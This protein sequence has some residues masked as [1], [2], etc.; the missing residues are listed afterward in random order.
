MP[1]PKTAHV[2]KSPPAFLRNALHPQPMNQCP[3]S[4]NEADPQQRFR[5]GFGLIVAVSAAN[6]RGVRNGRIVSKKPG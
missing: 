4:W 5:A 1:S 2:A 3:E 6:I